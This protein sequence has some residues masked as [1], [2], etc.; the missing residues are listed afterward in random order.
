MCALCLTRCACI[1]IVCTSTQAGSD[2]H[3]VHHISH[4]NLWLW[5]SAFAT[6]PERNDEIGTRDMTILFFFFF[7]RICIDMRFGHING[8]VRIKHY[9]LVTFMTPLWNRFCVLCC[10]AATN[11]VLC[12]FF[13]LRLL[14]CIQSNYFK[15][16][17]S[18]IASIGI[19][20]QDCVKLRI[21][22]PR[23][24]CDSNYQGES[25]IWSPFLHHSNLGMEESKSLANQRT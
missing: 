19:K 5:A 4:L 7:E 16:F 21:Q 10:S 15:V 25:Y 2:H 18:W 22:N 23:T 1:W 9:W 12:I 24:E 3:I 8:H 11:N 6:E 13:A 14:V 20:I 17:K